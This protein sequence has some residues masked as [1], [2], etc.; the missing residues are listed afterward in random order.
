MYVVLDD[1]VYC[2]MRWKPNGSMLYNSVHGKSYPA[3]STSRAF[4]VV[5]WVGSICIVFSSYLG[6][7]RW[8]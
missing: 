3:Y 7:R 4:A 6:P 2:C 5:V 8:K 1:R